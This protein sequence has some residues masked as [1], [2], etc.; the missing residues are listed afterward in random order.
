MR[1][2]IISFCT[3]KMVQN[4][5]LLKNLKERKMN[6]GLQV[7]LSKEQSD[8]LK[9]YIYDLT[10]EAVKK[11]IHNA[12]SDK[13]FLN[14]KEMSDWVGVSVNT[15]KAYVREGLPIIVMGGRNFYSKKEVSKFLL[16]RQKGGL[17]D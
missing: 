5:E 14:Q 1:K 16:S 2:M 12:G 9:S 10:N 13:D 15:L 11:A 3:K 17:D 7:V 8:E 6:M 4:E